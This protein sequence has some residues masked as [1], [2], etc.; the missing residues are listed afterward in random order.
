M[1]LSQKILKIIDSGTFFLNVKAAIDPM[2]ILDVIAM[3]AFAHLIPKEP[4]E[5]FKWDLTEILLP[6]I[7]A[8]WSGKSKYK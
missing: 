4:G 5:L 8:M 6:T 2:H 3:E 1:N 7:E